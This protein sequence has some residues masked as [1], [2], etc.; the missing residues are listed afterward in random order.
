MSRSN[1][2][3]AKKSE[4]RT[5]APAAGDEQGARF[6]SADRPGAP[7]GSHQV[8]RAATRVKV[9]EAGIRILHE[10]GYHAATTTHVAKTAGVSRGALLHQFPTHT[11]MLLAI[12]EYVIY[13]NQ[14]RTARQLSN[15]EPGVAQF[16]ALTE[17][18]WESPDTLALIEIHLASRSNPE[19]A[20]GMGWRIKTLL[21]A[22]R[23]KTVHMGVKAGIEDRRLIMALS[24]LTVASI[25]GLSILRLDLWDEDDINDAFELLTVNRDRFVD[26]HT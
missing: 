16:K 18:L 25:W 11:E 3:P 17:S 8:R 14:Q 15:I 19:L 21:D 10:E 23:Q 12:A 7:R 4:S 2:R 5:S 1:D 24:T 26:E 9:L 20:E 13:K 22:E 6:D